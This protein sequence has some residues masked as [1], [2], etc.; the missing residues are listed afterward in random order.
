MCSET[1]LHYFN[2]IYDLTLKYLH[3]AAMDEEMIDEELRQYNPGQEYL[4]VGPSGQDYLDV[5]PRQNQLSPFTPDMN[6]AASATDLSSNTLRS[7]I[8]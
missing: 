1:L 5:D 2:S 6:R 8:F 4:D 7:S 3:K